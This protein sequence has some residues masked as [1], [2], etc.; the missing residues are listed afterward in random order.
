MS[1]QRARTHRPFRLLGT[2]GPVPGCSDTRFRT[3]LRY[4]VR[5]EDVVTY[6]SDNAFTESYTTTILPNLVALLRAG[7]IE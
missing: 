1:F 7:S 5:F 3:A 6:S 2:T 4:G